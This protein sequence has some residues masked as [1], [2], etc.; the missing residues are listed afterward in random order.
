[1]SDPSVT[2]AQG[3]GGHVRG[4]SV[5]IA[6]RWVFPIIWMILIAVVAAALVKL[7]FFPDSSTAA[8]PATPTGE[9]TE[10]TIVVGRGTITNDL[11]LQGTVA[12]DPAVPVKATA[13]GT[14][15]DIYIPQGAAVAVGDLIFDIKVET[16][17]DPVET[18]NPDGTT[19]I[20]QPKP[21]VSF[22]RVYAGAAGVLSSLTV[23]HDQAVTVGEVAGQIAPPS[24]S[25]TGTIEAD[26]LYR[27][28]ARPTEAT[29]TITNGPAPFTCTGLAITTPLAGATGSDS[30]GD[31]GTGTG[32]AAG[33]GTS[34]RCAVP[35]DVTVFPGLA[36]SVVLAGGKA[37]NV[38]V[39]PTTAVEGT[40]QSGI[41]YAWNEDGT[42][43]EKPV[44]LGLS[45]GSN[46]EVTGGLDEG[47][48][49]LQFV[50]GAAAPVEGPVQMFGGCVTAPDGS[51]VCS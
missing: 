46:V 28:Q 21:A 11:T 24:F 32:G 27:I 12:A 23:I 7:A 3:F 25:V 34:F 36:A 2:L 50:P 49:L 33:S 31:P 10:P 42:T 40:A 45:D 1:M 48:V 4:R 37:E 43:E 13:I 38:L 22:E 18:T 47:A 5:G 14:V 17:Q 20:T 15:D 51:T 39:V 26:K 6:R 29:I 9:I 41:V 16:P 35:A 19:T 44:T 30:T 8:D